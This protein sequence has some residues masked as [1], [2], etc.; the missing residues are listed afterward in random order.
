[1]P[2]VTPFEIRGN[3]LG[4]FVRETPVIYVR[5]MVSDALAKLFSDFNRLFGNLWVET[6][7][8][9][10]REVWLPKTTIA[11]FDTSY[12]TLP[13]VL[14]E[15]RKFDFERRMEVK[16][17]LMIEYDAVHEEVVDTFRLMPSG[18]S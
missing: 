7:D 17:I 13:S 1:M 4:V 10:L 3:G 16:Q 18:W 6:A 15:I 12:A 5:W 2:E 9:S 8:S 14:G 11:C